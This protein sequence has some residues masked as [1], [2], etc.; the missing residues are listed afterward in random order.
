MERGE[1]WWADVPV[2]GRRPVLLLSRNAVYGARLYMT[3]GPLPVP[4]E[5]CAPR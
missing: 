1:V 5:D 3:V 2:A 4:F